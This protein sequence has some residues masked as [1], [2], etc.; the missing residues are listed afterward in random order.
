MKNVCQ[1]C[2]LDLQYGLPV[3]VRDAGRGNKNPI[4]VSDV[5]R[6]YF[7][8]QAEKAI[9]ASGKF[10]A[11]DNIDDFHFLNKIA[12]KDPYYKRN[13][14]HICSFF[15]RGQC[16]RGATCPYRHVN[17]DEEYDPALSKQNFKDR[18]YG[19]N[20]P[21]ALKMLEK[22]GKVAREV[23]PPEDKS[24]KTLWLGGI[25]PPI[26]EKDVKDHLYSYGEITNIRMVPRS[27]CCFVTFT[28]RASAESA[29]SAL[30]K[31]FQMQG[32]SVIVDWAKPQ[33][34]LA[35]ESAVSV[36]Q[37][38]G[39]YALPPPGAPSLSGMPAPYYPSM[40]P[41]QFGSRVEPRPTRSI[42]PAP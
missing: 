2:L 19:V 38:S 23:L 10:G 30:S 17:P 32:L 36:S 7:A 14:A 26:D 41:A 16:T 42:N 5:N 25:L 27:N 11:A 24:I 4:P 40:D 15:V 6:E 35:G 13:E 31:G 29:A 12:R 37:P 28:E 39:Y 18:Y 33:S 3:Q 20:D 8:D 21:V 1:V 34:L 22:H 9:E